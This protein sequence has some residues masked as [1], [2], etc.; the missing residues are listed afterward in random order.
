MKSASDGGASSQA[1]PVRRGRGGSRS[2]PSNAER[3]G[4]CRSHAVAQGAER[5]EK[6]NAGVFT[7]VQ[8]LSSKCNR[9]K[10]IQLLVHRPGGVKRRMEFSRKS[11]SRRRQTANS[12]R[13]RNIKR[14]DCQTEV[15]SS[16]NIEE[17]LQHWKTMDRP[18]TERL[19]KRLN[20]L[21]LMVVSHK[22]FLKDF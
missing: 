12:Q 18:L 1:A 4:R 21:C 9:F 3:G 7:G 2:G 19:K 13:E 8:Y 20:S 22:V 17:D 16:V 10:Q 6:M 11:L 5:K 15:K 14:R